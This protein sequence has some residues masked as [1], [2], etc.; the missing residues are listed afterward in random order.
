MLRECERGARPE[1][2]DRTVNGWLKTLWV[3][4]ERPTSLRSLMEAESELPEN[5]LGKPQTREFFLVTNEG[6]T[7]DLR[8]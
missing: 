8:F 3:S 5:A 4:R 1:E 7:V 2:P 6:R